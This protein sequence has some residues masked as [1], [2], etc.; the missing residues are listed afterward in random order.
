M[1]KITCMTLVLLFTAFMAYSQ[2]NANNQNNKNN[3]DM[4][5][6]VAYFSAT[7]TTKA[8]SKTL[9]KAANADVYEIIPEKLYTSADLNWQNENSRSSLENA[10]EKAR[11]ALA[12]KKAGIQNYDVIFLGFPIWWY[13]A[14]KIINTFLENYDFSGKTIILFATSG[15]SRLGKSAEYLKTSCSK[16]TVIKDGKIFQ[17]N[18]SEE[19]LK[20]WIKSLNL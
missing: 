7:G 4:K 10:D 14:P 2:Q 8:V 17:K 1:K 12:D 19:E 18:T 16:T 5:I 11:P 3:Q 9:A 20:T 6:L 13:R 15:G